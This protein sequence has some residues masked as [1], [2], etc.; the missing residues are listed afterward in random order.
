MLSKGYQLDSSGPENLWNLMAPKTS[1][2]EDER[3]ARHPSGGIAGS[4]PQSIL[5]L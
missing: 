2:N 3:K 1:I 4:N 5:E